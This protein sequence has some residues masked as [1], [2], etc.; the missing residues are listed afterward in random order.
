MGVIIILMFTVPNSPWN[1][2]FAF[3]PIFPTSAFVTM[4]VMLNCLYFCLNCV[5]PDSPLLRILPTFVIDFHLL[6]WKYWS[7]VT[8]SPVKS[9]STPFDGRH[10]DSLSSSPWL[11]CTPLYF[12]SCKSVYMC[13]AKYIYVTTLKFLGTRGSCIKHWASSRTPSD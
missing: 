2:L 5:V 13:A 7:I 11:L 10:Q 9:C 12:T 4:T 1:L 8:S 6:L 3:H